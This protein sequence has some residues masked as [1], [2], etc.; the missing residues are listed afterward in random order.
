MSL[1]PPHQTRQRTTEKDLGPPCTLM[2]TPTGT[3]VY[4]CAVC[5]HMYHVRTH[6]PQ[7]EIIEIIMPALSWCQDQI[8]AFRN[9]TSRSTNSLNSD[10]TGFHTQFYESSQASS[11]FIPL[12][13]S[14]A[15]PPCLNEKQILSTC[16]VF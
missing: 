11:L 12:V 16:T 13:P 5:V 15:D 9:K 3:C 4:A 2:S 8:M 1:T 7:P 10:R 14:S 6:V